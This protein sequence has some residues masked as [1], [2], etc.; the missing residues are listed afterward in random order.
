[1]KINFLITA[2]RGNFRAWRV[3]EAAAGRPPR[4]ESAEAFALTE[5]HLKTSEK[6][7]DQA[8]GFPAQ[9]GGGSRQTVQGNSIAERHYDIEET[10]RIVRQLAGHIDSVLGR[11]RPASWSFAAPAEILESVL[12]EVD[13]DSRASLVQKVPRDLVN[14]PAQELYAHFAG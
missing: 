8:G 12:A 11:E 1:M 7:T 2:D 13:A 4:I 6:F 5:A 10:R 14:V 9:T 3:L